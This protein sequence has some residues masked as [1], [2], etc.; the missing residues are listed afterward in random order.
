MPIDKTFAKIMT[1]LVSLNGIWCSIIPNQDKAARFTTG[2]SQAIA[3]RQ[4]LTGKNDA[5]PGQ[6]LRVLAKMPPFP[7]D[8]SH[9]S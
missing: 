9:K 7:F 6:K 5:A 1:T 4:R 3:R 2:F 8:A